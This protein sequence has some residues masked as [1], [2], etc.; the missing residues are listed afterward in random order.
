M[1]P[2]KEAS[3]A[4]SEATQIILNLLWRFDPIAW[5]TMTIMRALTRITSWLEDEL[6]LEAIHHPVESTTTTIP[7]IPTILQFR[8]TTTTIFCLSAPRLT[9]ERPTTQPAQP[10]AIT[11]ETERS[12]LK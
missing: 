1:L 10:A 3:T 7:T 8:S 2:G 4:M 12:C 11:C 9:D 5:L 6:Q